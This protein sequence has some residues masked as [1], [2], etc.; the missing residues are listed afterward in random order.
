M[1]LQVTKGKKLMKLHRLEKKLY[2][3]KISAETFKIRLVKCL[4]LFRGKSPY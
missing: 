4:E 3:Y 1:P 2:N